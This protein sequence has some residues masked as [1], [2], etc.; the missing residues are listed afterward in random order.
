KSRGLA[1]AVSMARELGVKRVAIPT[2]GNAGGALAAYAARAGLECYVFMPEDTP[3]VNRAEAAL[4][5]AKA[6][7]V[8]GLITDCAKIVRA[9]RE[10]LR[11]GSA[12]RRA[13]GEPAHHRIGAA[14]AAGSRG[15]HDPGRGARV[16]RA[17]DRRGRIKT[18]GMDAPGNEIGGNIPLPGVRGMHRS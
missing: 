3:V 17:G 13:G 9:D 16:W 18:G 4:F 2:A 6:F 8:N 1:M 7:V 5:G 12:V 15:L 11:K 10:R 14:R